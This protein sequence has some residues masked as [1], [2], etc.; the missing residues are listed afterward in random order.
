MAQSKAATVDEYL[1]E[2]QPERTAALGRIRALALEALP[3]HEERMHW[4]MAA[5]FR[6]GEAEFAWANQARYISVYLMK[7][8]VATAHADELAGL[9]FGKSCL[10]LD[11]KQAVDETLLRSLLATTAG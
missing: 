8:G 4:G 7:D 2:A 6:D 9:D 3:D 11:P 1:A 5:Y 10:R